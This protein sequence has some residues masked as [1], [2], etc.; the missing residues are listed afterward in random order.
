M[1]VQPVQHT[2]T[3]DDIEIYAFEWGQPGGQQVLLIHATGFHARCWDQV[4]AQ[5]PSDWHIFAVDM[6]GHGRSS[7]I[8]PYTWAQFGDDL[9]AIC[10][11]LSIHDAI[12]VGHSM[13]GHCV[14]HAAGHRPE[15]FR[16]LV[17]VDPVIMPPESY[18]AESRHDYASPKDHPIARR[19][20]H[21]DSVAQMQQR[22]AERM[23]YMLWQKDVFDDYCTHGLLPLGGDKGFE[24]ACPGEVEASIY[25][26]TSDASIF[27]LIPQIET[28]TVV[29][30]A[31][32]REVGSTQMDFSMSPTWP[33][34]AAM[35]P[36]GQDVHLPE[37]THFI[38][39]QDPRLV[40]DFILAGAGQEL[41]LER[42]A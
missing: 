23:P 16:H 29:L 34:L 37:L 9:L 1:S 8:A 28:P 35:F 10:E 42:Q 19:R 21:F 39:M 18:S 14:T 32:P 6:R 40:A 27:A 38:P 7:K 11:A 15:L 26:G 30:R 36:R 41:L 25:M 17:L 2:L 24:L 3:L 13:G 20:G 31:S 33:Q 5:L 12:A 4:V 22:Y